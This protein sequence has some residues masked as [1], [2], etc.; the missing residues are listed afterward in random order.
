MS[1]RKKLRSSGGEGLHPPKPPKNS[2][3]ENTSGVPQSSELERLRPEETEGKSGPTPSAQPSGED[4]AQVASSSPDED[5]AVPPGLLGQSEK[6][7]VP[8]PLSQN[9]I[10]KFVPQF[11]K[12]R[13]IMTRKTE[14]RGEDS[15]NRAFHPEIPPEPRALQTGSQVLDES[16]GLEIPEAGEPGYGACLEQSG[17]TPTGEPEP[18]Q[19][20]ALPVASADVPQ[21]QGPGPSGLLGDGQ[22][23]L[24]ERLIHPATAGDSGS[25]Q[26]EMERGLASGDGGQEGHLQSSRACGGPQEEGEDIPGTLASAPAQGLYPAAR[27]APEHVQTPSWAGGEVEWSYH[28]SQRRSSPGPVVTAVSAEAAEPGQ[29]APEVAGPGGQAET[30]LSASPGG[31]A[32][33][34]D[35][36]GAL[37]SR[38]PLTW[39]TPGGQGDP[40]QKDEP[41]RHAPA[42]PLASLAAVHGN[43]E[44]V[45]DAVDSSPQAS[46]TGLVVHQKPVPG[47][48]REG[49]GDRDTRPSPAEAAG[50][51]AAKIGSRG[52]EQNLALESPGLPSRASRPPEHRG[53]GDGPSWEPGALQGSPDPHSGLAVWPDPTPADQASWEGCSAVELNFLPDSQIRD[54]LD[55]PDLQVPPEQHIWGIFSNTERVVHLAQGHDAV[56]STLA[57]QHAAA[58]ATC[59]LPCAPP[60]TP[61]PV[62]Q[63]GRPLP[64]PQWSGSKLGPVAPELSGVLASTTCQ[65]RCPVASRPSPRWP[66]PSPPAHRDPQAQPRGDPISRPRASSWEVCSGLPSLPARH[67]RGT[68]ACEAARMEDA[69]GIVCGLV[70][71]LSS[72]NRLIMGAH[73]DLE[74][75][76]RLGYR[77]AK[78]AGKGPAPHAS[79]GAAGLPWGEQPWRDL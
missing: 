5:T 70:M 63:H 38:P 41:P 6:D 61:R 16:L 66:G 32:P 65:E 2:R 19:G 14:T 59:R 11:A 15:G 36:G 79:K 20:G 7:S 9:S 40:E 51:K 62:A 24:S 30:R 18:S 29:G 35:H 67:P 73:R 69:T 10:G 22:N 39:E 48:S 46:E 33:D 71:E 76:K 12:P 72:L 57:A 4:P 60:E 75:C 25:S 58:A 52:H 8:F 28:S 44:P 53:A 13:K 55:T 43:R 54:A 26:P 21:E 1:K 23:H 50:A 74:A 68:E 42:G 47:P 3:Q 64:R 17:Q 37:L 49:L 27:D 56:P 78:P 31:K 77:K 34:G 45:V